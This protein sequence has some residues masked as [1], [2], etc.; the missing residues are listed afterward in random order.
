MEFDWID[1]IF[2]LFCSFDSHT[3]VEKNDFLFGMKQQN[4][5]NSN[6][7]CFYLFQYLYIMRARV[8]NVVLSNKKICRKCRFSSDIRHFSQIF[9]T[10]NRPKH[11]Q[12]SP[13]VTQYTTHFATFRMHS[14]HFNVTFSA[15]SNGMNW[16]RKPK[17]VRN[18]AERAKE[19]M[20]KK[21][22]TSRN[23]HITYIR[24]ICN[25]Y[26][27]SSIYLYSEKIVWVCVIRNVYGGMPLIQ[28]Y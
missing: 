8:L 22:V 23:I 3:R 5:W 19:K 24:N 7:E 4:Q 15:R 18:V 6:F 2:L 12:I 26:I 25:V 11:F 16:K 21:R 17:N 13:T 1:T 28:S 14:Q 20:K 27:P 9:H 10:N